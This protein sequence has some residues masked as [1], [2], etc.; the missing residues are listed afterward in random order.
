MH[1]Q[2]YSVPRISSS[3][4]TDCPLCRSRSSNLSDKCENINTPDSTQFYVAVVAHKSYRN[5]EI[6]FSGHNLKNVTSTWLRDLQINNLI[7]TFHPF[8]FDFHTTCIP[9]RLFEIF[10]GHWFLSANS[11]QILH[12]DVIRVHLSHVSPLKVTCH[13]LCSKSD[14]FTT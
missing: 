5:C 4:C 14:S 13:F 10:L 7:Y 12:L 11:G 2:I 1:A 8:F 9:H 6:T 3:D